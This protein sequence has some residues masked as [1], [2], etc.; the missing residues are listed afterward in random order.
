MGSHLIHGGRFKSIEL[1]FVLGFMVY[2]WII[3]YAKCN[4]MNISRN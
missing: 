2:K 3:K 4:S 1:C